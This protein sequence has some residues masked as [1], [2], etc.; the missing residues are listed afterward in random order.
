MKRQILCKAV[1]NE[2][3]GMMMSSRA[4]VGK[5]QQANQTEV[6]ELQ[7]LIG[8]GRD[9]A[10]KL[11]AKITAEKN[12]YNAALAEYKVNHAQ[13]NA[14]KAALLDLLNAQK[15]DTHLAK[16]AQAIE[17]SWLTVN[18]QRGM[19][20]L[21]KDMSEDFEA[22]FNAS[23]DI[24]KLMQGVYNTF[25]EKFG[26]QKMK[27]PSLD[28]DPQRT[29]LQLLVM[30]T[31]QFVKDPVNVVVK[32]KHF[33]VKNFYNTLVKEARKNFAD[34][35]TQAERWIQ[36]VVLP[37]EVAEISA[38]W[39]P[40]SVVRREFSIATAT[41]SLGAV[42]VGLASGVKLAM[43]VGPPAPP[44]SLTCQNVPFTGSTFM[45][46]KSPILPLM[47]ADPFPAG[48]RTIGCIVPAASVA[49]RAVSR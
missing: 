5:K 18:L 38:R 8:K 13:F 30:Q 37:L 44:N 4:S 19:S 12:A 2:I 43:T 35:K 21:V 41:W 11:W 26:F 49:F 36:A 24:K 10:T 9:V 46:L 20:S 23:E 16:S 31:E 39:A 33:V 48:T 42:T 32:E 25:I 7:G 1:V 47:L 22:V 6:V 27:L 14:K 40:Y 17:D 3:G 45:P 15:L 34:A 29:K 28:L